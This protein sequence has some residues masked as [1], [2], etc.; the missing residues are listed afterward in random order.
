MSRENVEIVRIGYEQFAITGRFEADLLAPDFVWD[1]AHFDGWPEQAVYAGVEG[2]R[3]FLADWSDAWDDW[4]MDV[5]ALHDAGDRVV[6]V[7]HQRG[8]SKAAGMLVDMRFAQVWTFRDGKQTRMDTYSDPA[9]AL[10]AAGL[11]E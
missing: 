9:E 7:L 2:A 3:R 6:A 1:M 10:E 8:R 4:R 11:A 5:E